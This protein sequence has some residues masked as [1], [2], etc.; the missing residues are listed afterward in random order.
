MYRTING[1]EVLCCDLCGKPVNS[2]DEYACIGTIQ[3]VSKPAA[4][5]VS[6]CLCGACY[7][8]QGYG[9]AETYNAAKEAEQAERAKREAESN[10][11]D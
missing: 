9:M 5:R 11:Q 2:W 10:V 7:W 8:S 1:K 3:P 4:E 6:F